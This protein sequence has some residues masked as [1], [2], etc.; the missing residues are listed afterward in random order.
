MDYQN[1][2]FGW[3][4]RNWNSSFSHQQTSLE[5]LSWEIPLRLFYFLQLGNP[6]KTYAVESHIWMFFLPVRRSRTNWYSVSYSSYWK[7]MLETFHKP[8][9]ISILFFDVQKKADIFPASPPPTDVGSIFRL[10]RQIHERQP[11]S[12]TRE[13]FDGLIVSILLNYY[14]CIL[15]G[16]IGQT[17]CMWP[18]YFL[19]YNPYF[20]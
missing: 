1:G 12:L 2:V 6:L 11:Q 19:R 18:V 15:I 3:R 9:K 5:S 8:N 20:Q 16:W 4:E 13:F 10:R 17:F 14:F 7:N